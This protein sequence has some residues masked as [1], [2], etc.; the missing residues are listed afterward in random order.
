MVDVGYLSNSTDLSSEARRALQLVAA[1]LGAGAVAE[2]LGCDRDGV[3]RHLAD[4]IR[5]LSACSVPGAVR[6][7]IRRGLIEAPLYTKPG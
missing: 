7:A 4:A 3:R 6:E 1:G 2:R 5:D